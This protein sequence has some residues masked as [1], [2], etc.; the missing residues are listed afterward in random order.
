MLRRS[1]FD[2]SK[3]RQHQCDRDDRLRFADV[4]HG[5]ILWILTGGLLA[6][7]LALAAVCVLL[8]FAAVRRAEFFLEARCGKYGN[9]I[10]VHYLGKAKDNFGTPH[11]GRNHGNPLPQ[12]IAKKQALPEFVPTEMGSDVK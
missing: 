5:P 2:R 6:L 1:L 9:Y 7:A 11:G 10:S 8:F 4:H 3:Q 12:E